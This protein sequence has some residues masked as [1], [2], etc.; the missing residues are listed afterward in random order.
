M[1][2]II[3][4]GGKKKVIGVTEGRKETRRKR[5]VGERERRANSRE[6]KGENEVQD[7]RRRSKRGRRKR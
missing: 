4:K 1:K 7:A 2:C 5:K 3:R 6:G